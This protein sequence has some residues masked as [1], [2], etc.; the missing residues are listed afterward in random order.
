MSKADVAV[1]TVF[2]AVPH[3]LTDSLLLMTQVAAMTPGE[4]ERRRLFPTV[5]A[6]QLMG[7]ASPKIESSLMMVQVAAMTPVEIEM[8]TAAAQELARWGITEL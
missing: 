7:R 5:G 4:V 6:H 3:H 8:S 2:P 1:A